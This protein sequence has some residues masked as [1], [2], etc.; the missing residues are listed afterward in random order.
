[1]SETGL[2]RPL[3]AGISGS[4][5]EGADSVVLSGAMRTTR[6]LA[7]RSSTQVTA[8]ETKTPVGRSHTR[9][10]ARESGTRVQQPERPSGAGH[11]GCEPCF[12]VPSQGWIPIR[13]SVLG[14]RLLAG[15]REIRFSRLALHAT[16][17]YRPTG[18]R[19]ISFGDTGRLLYASPA[20][21]DR[22]AYRK[23]YQAGTTS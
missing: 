16:Q 17:G 8:V 21:N 2:H 19:N 10:F 7:T 18:H 20:R 4:E 1:L 23:R 22:A 15:N 3:I 12:A 5:R 9:S 13:R 11:Q 6:I 14:R